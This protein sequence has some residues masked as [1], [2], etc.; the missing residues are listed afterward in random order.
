[1]KKTIKYYLAFAFRFGGFIMS[2][3]TALMY[4][5]SNLIKNEEDEFN[6]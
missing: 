4:T 3:P 5:I 6:F 1:M 2:L